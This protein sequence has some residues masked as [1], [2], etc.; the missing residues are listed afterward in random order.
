MTL[1]TQ[2]V[3]CAGGRDVPGDEGP[4]HHPLVSKDGRSGP[5]F[6]CELHRKWMASRSVCREVLDSLVEGRVVSAADGLRGWLNA[7]ADPSGTAAGD[8]R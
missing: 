6:I 7:S 4:P 3:G 8:D 5:C 2:N 1:D